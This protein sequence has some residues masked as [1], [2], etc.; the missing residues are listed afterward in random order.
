MPFAINASTEFISPTKTL[1]YMA[2]GKPIVSTPVHD[3]RTVFGDIVAIAG[4]ASAFIAECRRALAE[5]AAERREREARMEAR[6]HEHSWDR[7]AETIR[8]SLAAV[9]A[10]PRRDG[11]C[12]EVAAHSAGAPARVAALAGATDAD[13]AAEREAGDAE[14]Q[15]KIASA[16]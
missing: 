9:L 2:A 5:P 3:V 10:A 12:A 11:P 14:T 1:E 13:A 15:R 4:D 8:R 7:A 16:G 6:V